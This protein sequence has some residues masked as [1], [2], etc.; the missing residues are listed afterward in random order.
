MEHQQRQGQRRE[1]PRLPTE[2]VVLI[3]QDVSVKDVGHARMVSRSWR[4][5]VDKNAWILWKAQCKR[6]GMLPDED[7][8]DIGWTGQEVLSAAYRCRCQHESECDKGK[9]VGLGS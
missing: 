7:E 4:D 2:I 5:T 9:A 8:T 1:M 6:L 3:L